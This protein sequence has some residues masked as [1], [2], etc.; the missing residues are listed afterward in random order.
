M[1]TSCAHDEKQEKKIKNSKKKNFLS[2]FYPQGRIRIFTY[3]VKQKSVDSFRG[4]RCIILSMS[5]VTIIR[6]TGASAEKGLS[7]D[8]YIVML[9]AGLE[10]HLKVLSLGN[11]LRNLLP[12]RVIG[13]KTNCLAGKLNSTPIAL[14]EA[15]GDLLVTEGIDENNLVIWERQSWELEKAGYKLNASSFGRRCFGTDSSIA[16][17]SRDFYNSGKANSLITRIMT[18]I[19]DSNINLPVLKDHSIAGLSGGLKNMFGAINNPNKYH[20]DNCN[21]YA[22]HVSSLEP[23]RSKNKLTIIDAVKVQYNMGPGYD[24]RYLDSYGGLIIS[25]DPVAA[26]RIGLEILEHI[27]GRH[28]QPTLEVAGRP[29]K[30]LKEAEEIGLGTADPKKIAVDVIQIN[31][32][33][34][35]GK[36]EMF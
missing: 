16:G 25:S 15:I 1:E 30:Y 36:G 22:A 24:S 12:G 17:Y 9:N 3:T 8:D 6:K 33:G 27:R 26:D 7:K 4:N 35:V 14:T 31:S 13:M 19:V 11:R 18:D 34:R 5:Q 10:R 28:N 20:A 29:V 23:I 2:I 21:P 32:N